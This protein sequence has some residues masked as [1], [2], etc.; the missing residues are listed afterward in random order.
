MIL[1]FWQVREF[2]HKFIIELHVLKCIFVRGSNKK[3]RRRSIISNFTKWEAFSSLMTTKCSWGQS[4]NVGPLLAPSKNTFLSPS[5]WP[6]K[7]YTWTLSW[8]DS[9][10]ICFENCQ[11]G[12]PYS[13][14]QSRNRIMDTFI[15]VNITPTRKR[16]LKEIGDKLFHETNFLDFREFLP[17]TCN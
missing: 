12:V 1:Y 16:Y 17:N 14:R 5:I 4:H 3:Q 11:Q 9:L 2:I 10:L 6:R 15:I 7:E 8:E 13:I